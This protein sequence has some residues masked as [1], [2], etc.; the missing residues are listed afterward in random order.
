MLSERHQCRQQRAGS[1]QPMVFRAQ[2]CGPCRMSSAHEVNFLRFK[3]R[4]PPGEAPMTRQRSQVDQPI[5][6]P[7]ARSIV[8]RWLF[9][10]QRGV[11]NFDSRLLWWAAVMVAAV[12]ALVFEVSSEASDQLL[13]NDLPGVLSPSARGVDAGQ[14]PR[15]DV[16]MDH[17]IVNEHS[18]AHESDLPGASIAEW[19][20]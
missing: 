14:P 17:S 16:F 12:T 7:L 18:T 6:T 3:D 2:R 19:G 4:P 10:L 9:A 8:R 5:S 20:P 1:G 13:G 11:A 15:Y